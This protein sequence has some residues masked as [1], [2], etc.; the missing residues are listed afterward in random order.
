MSGGAGHIL[1]MMNRIRQN[2]ALKS[3]RKNKFKGNNR[4]GIYSK[5]H[6]TKLEFDFPKAS[7]D[8]LEQLKNNLK[9]N[10]TKR[11]IN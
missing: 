9:R 7:K 11:K 4:S 6:P 3:S 5:E 10:Q 2:A 1:D 8:E